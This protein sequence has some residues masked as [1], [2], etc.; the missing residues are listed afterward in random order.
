MPDLIDFLEGDG[1]YTRYSPQSDGE[2]FTDASDMLDGLSTDYKDLLGGNIAQKFFIPGDAGDGVSLKLE[3]LDIDCAAKLPFMSK[4]GTIKKGGI[5]PHVGT[6]PTVP[7][8]MSDAKKTECFGSEWSV[9][10][11]TNKDTFITIGATAASWD[12][13]STDISPSCDSQILVNE[14]GTTSNSVSFPNITQIEAD[15]ILLHDDKNVVIEITESKVIIK[16][17]DQKNDL[18]IYTCN[19]DFKRKEK[20]GTPKGEVWNSDSTS[21]CVANTISQTS[22]HDYS[23]S[24]FSYLLEKL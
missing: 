22:S 13:S 18:N 21:S 3:S 14:I 2:A 5:Y 19:S 23:V 11:S 12:P 10:A 6:Y 24:D 17:A 8:A 16:P 7:S 1:G 4:H 20:S 15:E 9:T